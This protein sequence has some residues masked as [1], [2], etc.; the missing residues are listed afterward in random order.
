MPL[1]GS[2]F[3]QLGTDGATGRSINSE[4]GY[5]NDM[6]SYQGVYYGIGGTINRFPLPGNSLS[7]SNFYSTS[8]I[9]SG[10]AFI[11]SSQNFVVPVY[12]TISI[13]CVGGS[14]GQEGFWGYDCSGNRTIAGLQP[15][16][17]G[18][19]SSFGGYV[20]AGGGAGGSGAFGGGAGGAAGATASGSFTNPFQGGGGP[21]SGATIFAAVGGGGSGGRGAATRFDFGRCYYPWPDSFAPSGSA[22]GPGYI[23]VSWS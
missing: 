9:T 4:F 11:S 12:N 7:I 23:S 17:T 14:G 8:R 3:L 21:P 1:P 10:S 5:G 13:V 20:A 18:G 16:G 22:G 6:A 2:G 15:G 19:V